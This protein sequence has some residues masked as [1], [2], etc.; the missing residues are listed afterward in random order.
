MNIKSEKLNLAN[1][2]STSIEGEA[3]ALLNIKVCEEKGLIR[4]ENTQFVPNLRMNLLSVSKITQHGFEVVF[5]KEKAVV[6][7]PEGNVKL[8]AKRTNSL[9]I[10][11]ELVNQVAIAEKACVSNLTQ[12]EEDWHRRFGHLNPAISNKQFVEIV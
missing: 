6:L 8:A 9:Y 12:S 1:C 10:V 7:D 5:D 11:E 2:E 3:T 4:L